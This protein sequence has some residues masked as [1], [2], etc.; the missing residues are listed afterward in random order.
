MPTSFR[1]P[2]AGRASWSS[3]L[4]SVR[5][6]VATDAAALAE[7]AERTFRDAFASQNRPEDMD[8]HCRSSYGQEIQAVEIR[9]PNRETLVCESDGR[10]IGYGQL[11]WDSRSQGVIGSRPAEVQRIYVDSRWH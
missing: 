7:L 5:A 9:D 1:A 11:R 4:H 3:T 10:L 2:E 6:A 8:Q